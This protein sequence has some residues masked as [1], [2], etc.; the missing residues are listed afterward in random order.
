MR[1]AKG[2]G[3]R[4]IAAKLNVSISTVSRALN[5]D[6]RISDETIETILKTANEMGYHHPKNRKTIG[7]ILPDSQ[8]DL[9]L[10]S[11][12][13]INSL[14]RALR[15]RNYFWEFVNCDKTDILQER[16][17]SGLI[18]M[19]Y[20]QSIAREIRGK[21]Q[22]AIVCINNKPYHHE[23]VYSVNS[24]ASS[25]IYLSFKHLYE[26]GHRKIAFLPCCNDSF[27]E[28]KRKN[29]FLETAEKYKIA[30]ECLYLPWK[31]IALYGLIHELYKNGFTGIIADGETEGLAVLNALK[32]CKISV[33]RKMSLITWETPFVSRFM[34]PPITTVGQNFDALAENAVELL[35]R[36][37]NRKPIS[38]DILV[39]YHLYLR[40]SVALPAR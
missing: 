8:F 25:A 14:M 24:D 39:P 27:S 9:E 34:D 20:S 37:M 10:Y 28:V 23:N 31:D 1:K 18:L 4:E 6:S 15:K 17:L 30:Q 26:Y 12:N 32:Y 35:E 11:V 38:D 13:M 40:S 29:F 21:Y 16:S 36:S 22:K 5:N 19:D 7:V 3:V 33:P 2:L